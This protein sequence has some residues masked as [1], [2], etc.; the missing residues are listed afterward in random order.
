ME[1]ITSTVQLLEAIKLLEIRQKEEEL[2]LKEQ[3]KITY[4]SLKPVSLIKSTMKDLIAAPDLKTNLLSTTLS[5]VSGYVSKKIV[6]GK[7]KSP[8]KKIIGSLLQIGVT[9][10]LSNKLE[11]V[12][13]GV[14]N[15]IKNVAKK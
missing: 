12:V 8:I 2:L 5:I 3:F 4:E 10:L 7:G 11:G 15:V 1:K 13:S 9:S 14:V 6:M